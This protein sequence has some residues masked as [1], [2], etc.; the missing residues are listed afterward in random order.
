[1]TEGAAVS[2]RDQILAADDLGRADVSC[3]E[4]EEGLV[5]TVRGLTAGEV[6]TF[7]RE[8]NSGNLENVMARMV[9]RV[10]MNGDGKRLFQDDDAEALGG[11]NPKPIQ[12]LFM[13][14]QGLSGI[15]GDPEEVGNA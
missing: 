14:A 9:T 11:K 6:E 8:V 5:L 12:R 3:P 1:M 7:G 10:V 13:A 15:E 2:L 4:W